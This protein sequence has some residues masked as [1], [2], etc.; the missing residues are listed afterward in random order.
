MG[1]KCEIPRDGSGAMLDQEPSR[2]NLSMVPTA[3]GVASHYDRA[4]PQGAE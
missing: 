4:L 1:L 3:I 2:A